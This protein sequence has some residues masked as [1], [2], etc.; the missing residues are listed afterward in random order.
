MFIEKK[1]IPRRTFLQ[2]LLGTSL[3]SAAGVALLPRVSWAGKGPTTPPPPPVAFGYHSVITPLGR[4]TC[5][6]TVDGSD[7]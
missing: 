7:A 4:S 5:T 1:H 3:A 6:D 2:Q